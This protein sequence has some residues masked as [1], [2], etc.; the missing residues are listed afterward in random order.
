MD[1]YTYNLKTDKIQKLVRQQDYSTAAKIADTIDWKQE[2]NV[3]LLTAVAEAYEKTEQYTAATDVLL[4]AYEEASMGKRI[5]YKLTELALESGHVN[6]AETFYKKYLEE[7]PEEND[8]YILRYLIA[9]AKGEDLDKRIVIL[10]T[11]RK[12]EFEEQWACRLAELYQKANR[13]DEC[14]ALCDQII[15]WFGVG[16]YVD[17][18]MELKEMYEPL[19]ASQ[20]ERRENK[21]F[22]EARLAEMARDEEEEK[23]AEQS[24]EEPGASSQETE[25]AGESAEDDLPEI[26]LSEEVAAADLEESVGVERHFVP[27]TEAE[28]KKADRIQAMLFAASK[29]MSGASAEEPALKEAA[30]TM[31]PLFEEETPDLEP[32]P[33]PE[34]NIS[35]V[36]E[37]EPS[38]ESE[39]EDLEVTREFTPARARETAAE[40]PMPVF[41]EKISREETAA[42][43]SEPE[44][45]GDVAPVLKEEEI[46]AAEAVQEPVPEAGLPE[47]AESQDI[48]SEEN[49]DAADTTEGPVLRAA[50]DEPFVTET[51]G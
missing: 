12:Y 25:S 18:A 14:V 41:P 9:E 20:R 35:V 30:A 39:S 36:S 2:H 29:K 6:D 40:E 51:P 4:T 45:A 5:L 3:R 7:A 31:Q 42:E 10:E 44:P 24:G 23:P 47:S 34:E 19:T 26:A 13:K 27:E 1:K 50:V 16:P 8:R 11:Y 49:A 37:P 28:E 43:T 38:L 17:K 46:S 22:Y 33:L 48:Q 32:E 15:L 21:A